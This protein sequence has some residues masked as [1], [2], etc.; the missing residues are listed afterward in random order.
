MKVVPAAVGSDYVYYVL[1]S[2][3]YYADEMFFVSRYYCTEQ[4]AQHAGYKN[5]YLPDGRR[6]GATTPL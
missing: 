1:P 6:S 2:S 4:D 3:I 5:G